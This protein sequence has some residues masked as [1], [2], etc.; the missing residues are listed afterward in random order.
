MVSFDSRCQVVLAVP[1]PFVHNGLLHDIL[2]DIQDPAHRPNSG[3][4]IIGRR[5]KTI[6]SRGRWSQRQSARGDSAPLPLWGIFDNYAAGFINAFEDCC[7]N[8]LFAHNHHK[9][10][11]I[12]LTVRMDGG[13]GYAHCCPYR[14]PRRSTPK[15]GKASLLAVFQ[16]PG[17]TSEPG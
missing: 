5:P 13:G 1:G 17:L 12:A 9:I 11:K 3:I 15:K 14:R 6:P 10:R 8:E 4:L 7:G 2:R 16:L